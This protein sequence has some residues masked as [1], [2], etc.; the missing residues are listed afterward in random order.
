MA[1]S[2]RSLLLGLA[3]ILA[4]GGAPESGRV[5][6]QFVTFKPNQP[7][8]W[9]EAIQRFEHAHPSIQV[10]R[11]VGPHSS[12]ALHDMLTQKLK[13]R[14]R[15]VDVFFMD[16]VWPAEFAAAGWA[17]SL[18]DRFSRQE[19]AL[20][21]PGT[22]QANTW[23]EGIYGV[24]A[25]IDAGMLYYRADL[26]ERYGLRVPETWVELV[27]RARAIVEAEKDRTPELVGY[28]AQFKQYE[29]IVCDMLEFVASNRGRLLD[30][31]AGRA[32]L[33]D[34]ATLEA[35][36]W[37]RDQLIG[38]VAP[39]SVLTYQEPESLAVFLQ[40]HAVFHRNWPYAWEVANNEDRSRIVGRVGIAPLPRFEGARSASALGGWQ[41]GISAFSRYPEEAWSFVRFMTSPE[42]QR[43]FAVGAS[44]APTR[45]DLYAD[46][47]VLARNPQ[48]ADQASAFR[49]AVPRPV[50][51]VY[52]AVSEVLQRFFSTAVADPASDLEKLAREAST[53]TDGYLAMAR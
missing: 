30:E 10:A 13:N 26:L 32:T 12:T 44:L 15:S 43:H 8:V 52:A 1:F 19:R 17:L 21:L 37:V 4:C 33:Q 31:G 5:R 23:K 53:E 45:T 6:L 41:Y 27:D 7:E 34:P 3:W 20:F 36:R 22:I 28:T 38:A 2:T 14:D 49:N 47:E 39:R 46:P 29:G 50:T 16:V 51:P 24:P 9:D 11:Q 25:F 18:E 42:T 40:G 35:V 48:F